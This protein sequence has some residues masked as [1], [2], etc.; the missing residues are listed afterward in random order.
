[1]THTKIYV[2][3]NGT[4][5]EVFRSAD[6]PTDETY[7]DQYKAV[8]GPFQTIGG[9]RFMAINGAGNPHCRNVADA[10]KLARGQR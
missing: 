1:M 9:A 4:L 5:R 10:E 8:I 6:T 3:V 2:G 7:G